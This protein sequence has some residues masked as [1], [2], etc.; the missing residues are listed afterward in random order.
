MLLPS[1]SKSCKNAQNLHDFASDNRAKQAEQFNKFFCIIV[2]KSPNSVPTYQANNF[3]TYLAKRVSKSTYLEA[4]NINENVYTILSLNV[5]KGVGHD[6]IPAYF[7][8]I[9]P[10]TLAPFLLILIN[11]P[12][13]N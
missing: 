1:E 5:N 12:F 10:F 3:Q 7:L 6:K 2:E 9:V 11:Y 4:T 8:K 13:T